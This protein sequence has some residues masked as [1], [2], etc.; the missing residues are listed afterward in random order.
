MT[1]S[2]DCVTQTLKAASGPP[3]V[4]INRHTQHVVHHDFQSTCSQVQEI[5][6]TALP[7][8]KD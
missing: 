8:S 5:E 6:L 3:A 7:V 4:R 2:C 1:A